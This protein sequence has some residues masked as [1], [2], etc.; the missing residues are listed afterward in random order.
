[1]MS[2]LNY[3]ESINKFYDIRKYNIFEACM[4]WWKD[5]DIY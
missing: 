5:K 1:M 4:C 3:T 2:I